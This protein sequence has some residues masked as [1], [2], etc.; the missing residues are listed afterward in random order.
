[1]I[2][3]G[4]ELRPPGE[5][6][7]DQV[8]GLAADAG[9]DG[10]AIGAWY[11]REEALHLVTLAAASRLAVAVAGAPLL[12]RPLGPG[13]RLPFLGSLEDPEERRAAAELIATTIAAASPLGIGTFTISLGDVGLAVAP[14][15]LARSFRRGEMDEDEPGGEALAAALD[16]RRARSAGITDGCRAGLDLV[17]PAAERTGVTLAIELPAGPWGAPSPREAALLLDE[18]RE[19]PLGVVWDQARMSVLRRLGAAPSPERAARLRAGTRL[20]RASEAVGV[21]IGFLPGQGEPPDETAAIP[22]SERRVPVVVTG[23]PDSTLDELR[24][25]R[26]LT[27]PLPTPP[28]GTPNGR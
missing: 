5:R 23:R 25:A 3:L 20:W 11:R 4:T 17:I 14:E 19:A 24:R 13:K 15:R 18:Y 10:L 27:R 21:E 7:R 2:L 1:M 9:F 6:G 12:E 26:A 8:V 16:E 28:S 22:A